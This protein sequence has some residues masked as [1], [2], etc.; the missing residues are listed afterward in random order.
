[1]L[2][3]YPAVYRERFEHEM[4]RTFIE[5]HLAQTGVG[6]GYTRFL[7]REVWGVLRAATSQRLLGWR[8][9]AVD[10]PTGDASRG[11]GSMPG[12]LLNDLRYAVRTLR[13]SPSFTVV[14]VLSLALGIG[15]T[16][17]IFSALN[18]ILLRPLPFADPDRL[19]HISEN[20][21]ERPD[22]RR[23]P[24]YSTYLE[25]KEHSPAFEQLEV[26][27]YGSET[28]TYPG[29]DGAERNT[30]QWV[31]PGFFRLLGVEPIL[32]R[33][34]VAEDAEYLG[35]HRVTGAPGVIISYGFWQQNF[36]GDPDIVGQS[37]ANQE[38]V[39]V[40]PP[41]FRIFS[42]NE[43]NFW[44]PLTDDFNDGGGGRMWGRPIGCIH[45]T[46]I[47][48]KK[49]GSQKSGSFQ[50]KTLKPGGMT[51]TTGWSAHVCPTMSGSLPKRRCQK[52]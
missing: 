41:G 24:F 29:I 31:S 26:V 51:P 38:V 49:R 5:A 39:G 45:R 4:M 10:P 30:V 40:M 20:S 48:R 11:P 16:S 37:W 23:I 50:E 7:L 22:A 28:Y 1:M 42:W 44:A 32:G 18:P 15:A 52:P 43:A 6:K 25:W 27:I 34:F 14:V 13:K 19:V 17:T 8:R 9:V 2:R 47:S 21:T 46:P 33:N 36:G 35:S 12:I 3:A